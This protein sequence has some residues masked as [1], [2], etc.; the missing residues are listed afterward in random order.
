QFTPAKFLIPETSYYRPLYHLTLMAVWRN[1]DT[2]AAKL[3]LIK[4][5]HI[6]PIACLV[7]L[8]IFCL[9]PRTPLEAAAA[10]G[11]TAVLIGSP[12][13]RD[14]LEIPLSYT[15]VGM[16]L[17][18]IVWMLAERERRT[19]HGP[20][21]VALALIAIGFKEQGLVIIPV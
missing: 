8:F 5:L 4:L 17:A 7:V 16:P 14:N 9:R 18:L 12:G 21:I 2:L 20:A 6:V 15:A 11:A 13:F 19:W 3:V 1:A 10:A